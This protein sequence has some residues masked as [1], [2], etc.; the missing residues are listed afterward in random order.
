MNQSVNGS[1]MKRMAL[2]NDLSCFGKCSLSV[3]MPIIS[4]YGV[5]TVP[6]PTALLSTH[7]ASGFGPYVMRGMTE[8]MEAF[9]AHWKKLDIRFDGVCTGFFAS[10]S[11]LDFARR[12]LREFATPSTLVVVDP[13]LGDNGAL[14]GCFT[15]EYVQGM[16]DLC[17]CAQ[18]ITPNRT[19]AALLAGCP[20]DTDERDILAKLPVENVIITGV[21]ITGDVRYRD[22]EVYAP[23][24]DVT[25]LRRQIGMV[26]QK[27]NPF[28]M[29]VYDNIAYGPRTHGVKSRARLDEIVERSLRD[30]AIWD[31]VKDRLKKNALGLSGGQQ[32]RLC[33]ARALAVEPEVLLMDE[34]TSAL[35]PISTSK[36]ED[37]ALQ[38]KE[39]YTIVIVTHN[40]QQAV[41]ISDSTAFFL[42]GELVEF[43]DS[44]KLFSQPEDKRT[45][46][47]ITGRFG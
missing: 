12:F 40:M 2:L 35:D 20:M 27:P 3:A 14:Y 44:E 25:A 6:L 37:L 41:R 34:P 38:L 19:E 23:S 29:S 15:E 11:Q 16:R 4:A 31:E 47:Y 5:E 42:L 13:V 45:E 26:F 24:T 21:R 39:K 36:I 46:D 8:E 17:R 43:G 28:P 9:A 30:A 1:G 33:I 7:T 10:A 32:Q 18:L 22:M